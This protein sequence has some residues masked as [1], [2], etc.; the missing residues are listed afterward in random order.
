MNLEQVLA[1]VNR[2]ISFAAVRKNLSLERTSNLSALS[3]RVLGDPGKSKSSINNTM[4]NLVQGASH[5]S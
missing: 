2:I 4:I 1:D 3:K 5:R